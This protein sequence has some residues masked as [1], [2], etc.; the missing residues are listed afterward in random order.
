ME[1]M[2]IIIIIMEFIELFIYFQG[3]FL[4]VLLY[5]LKYELLPSHHGH[6]P[7]VFLD[8]LFYFLGFLGEWKQRRV[9]YEYIVAS[10]MRI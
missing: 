2:L 9:E 1:L 6:I 7:P 4:L 5:C 10:E 8:H 3:Y